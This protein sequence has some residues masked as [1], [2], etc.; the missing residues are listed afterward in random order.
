MAIFPGISKKYPTK[1][2]NTLNW[3]AIDPA[4]PITPA[5]AITILTDFPYITPALKY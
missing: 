2:P 4:E 3:I 5:T 1:L